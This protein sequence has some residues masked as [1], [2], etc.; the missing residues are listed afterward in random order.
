MA[1]TCWLCG[2]V[3][4]EG[5][6]R[7]QWPLP[8]YLSRRKL[9]P[10]PRQA[11][12]FLPVCHWCLSSCD[13]SAG[14]QREWVWISPCVGSLRGNGWDSRSFY[15]RLNPWWFLQPGVMETYLPGAG[16]L[17][18]E[19]WCRAGTPHSWDSPAK[20]VSTTRGCEISLFHVSAPPA[21]LDE[22]GFFNSIDMDFHCTRFLIVLGDSCCI[23]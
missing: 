11:L 8:T 1:P 6:E 14:A 10:S 16:T 17:G 15:H 20:I 13:P 21:S 5:S 2:S 4:G 19:A 3:V 9:S 22:C 7:R 18:W 12:Q 23:F